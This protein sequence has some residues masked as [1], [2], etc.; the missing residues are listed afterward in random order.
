MI[1]LHVVYIVYAMIYL[2]EHLTNAVL[3]VVSEHMNINKQAAMLTR[4]G[5]VVRYVE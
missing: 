1:H 2:T 4:D 5:L 3:V